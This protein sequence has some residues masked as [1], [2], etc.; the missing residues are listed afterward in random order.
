MF[1]YLNISSHQIG[2]V[3]T[4]TSK[5]YKQQTIMLRSFHLAIPSRI[6]TGSFRNEWPFAGTVQSSEYTRNIIYK[7]K[8]GHAFQSAEIID[9]QCW[10]WCSGNWYKEEL[11]PNDH[12]PY[13]SHTFD[14][15]S[16]ENKGG[17]KQQDQWKWLI[18]PGLPFSLN[19][20]GAWALT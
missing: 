15:F 3:E 4:W 2:I 20:H 14:I 19:Q 13:K 17:M 16:L 18:N 6:K 8:I 1:H 5:A 10:G 9:F 12:K 7:Q 11:T